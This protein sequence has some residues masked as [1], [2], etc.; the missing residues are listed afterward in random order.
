M[1][2]ISTAISQVLSFCR[3]SI[4]R[5]TTVKHHFQKIQ[6]YSYFCQAEIKNVVTVIFPLVFQAKDFWSEEGRKKGFPE[7]RKEGRRRQVN[8][9]GNLSNEIRVR[10]HFARC[11]AA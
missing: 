11:A 3:P 6:R 8:S 7:N 1:A 4:Y 5:E 9:K 10:I 2:C